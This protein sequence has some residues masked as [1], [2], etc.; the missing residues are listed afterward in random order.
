MSVELRRDEGPELK[1]T[2]TID[3]GGLC[4]FLTAMMASVK[5]SAHRVLA[6]TY[7]FVAEEELRC[8]QRFLVAAVE[9]MAKDDWLMPLARTVRAGWRHNLWKL[10]ELIEWVQYVRSAN[11]RDICLLQEGTYERYRRALFAGTLE[12]GLSTPLGDLLRATQ[13]PESPL[14][15]LTDA[16]LVAQ[17]Q[18]ATCDVIYY[19]EQ[20]QD[21]TE[22]DIGH[23]LDLLEAPTILLMQLLELARAYE[24][25]LSLDTEAR[26]QMLA[27]MGEAFSHLLEVAELQPERPFVLQHAE[28]WQIY[29]TALDTGQLSEKA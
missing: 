15:D 2:F 4:D 11:G 5:A 27:S 22:E 23:W 16:H 18:M 3:E 20:F 29:L 21:A 13:S 8:G 10:F 25:T 7:A 1:Y 9:A 12:P 28:T 6:K 17:A 24:W 26:T 14:R 19:F